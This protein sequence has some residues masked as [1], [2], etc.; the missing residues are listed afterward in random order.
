MISNGHQGDLP[1]ELPAEEADALLALGE[2]LRHGR[3]V[4][5]A[6]FRGGLRRSLLADRSIERPRALR[7]LIAGYVVAGLLMLAV[8]AAGLAGIGPF[9]PG[10]YS[11][12]TSAAV[13]S[14]VSPP[15][16][17]HG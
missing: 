16:P 11:A 12:S 17:A 14:D 6:S 5:R 10:S 9:A 8:P 15:V 7:L 2:R 4:P 1:L 13:L 3:P